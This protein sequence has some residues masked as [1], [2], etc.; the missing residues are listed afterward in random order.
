MISVTFSSKQGF[1]ETEWELKDRQARRVFIV[2]RKSLTIFEAA[3]L[4]MEEAQEVFQH[5]CERLGV[6]PVSSK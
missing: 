1:G 4:I 5:D 3:Q 6:G 2:N